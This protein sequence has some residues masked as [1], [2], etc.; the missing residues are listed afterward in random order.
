MLHTQR[1]LLKSTKNDKTNYEIWGGGE[2][3]KERKKKNPRDFKYKEYIIF[4]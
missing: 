4:N 1:A 2:G 3:K